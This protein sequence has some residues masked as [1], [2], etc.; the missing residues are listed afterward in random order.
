[1]VKVRILG[2]E[3]LLRTEASVEHTRAVAD[4]VDRTIRAIL[5]GS[6]TMETQ[7]AAILAALQITDELFREQR[8]MDVITGDM[9]QLASDIRPLLPP[10]K[11]GEDTGGG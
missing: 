6:S 5:A 1:M 8:A 11:R 10:A 3:Y 4:H 9:R 7:K 2:E